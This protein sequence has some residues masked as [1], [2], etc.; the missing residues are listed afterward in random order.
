M[1][2]R[3]VQNSILNVFLNSKLV[4]L[5]F[6][7]R[8]LPAVKPGS[9]GSVTGLRDKKADGVRSDFLVAWVYPN[10][11]SLILAGLDGNQD[12]I[13]TDETY[14]CHFLNDMT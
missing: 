13:E 6:L 10:L 9:L 7:L 2:N 12:Q 3:V 4:C 11:A 1:T 8:L 14:F 5:H